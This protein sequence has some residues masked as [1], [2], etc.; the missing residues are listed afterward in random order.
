MRH[1]LDRDDRMRYQFG[2]NPARTLTSE[3][4]RVVQEAIGVRPR[5]SSGRGESWLVV[6]GRPYEDYQAVVDALLNEF[7]A[8]LLIRE[9]PVGSQVITARDYIFF[10]DAPNGR[11][12]G[13]GQISLESAKNWGD[14]RNIII[15]YSYELEDVISAMNEAYEGVISYEPVD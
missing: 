2:S 13:S 1:R 7:R 6:Y 10:V 11:Y 3:I 4:G 5:R 12:L 15:H 14:S 8:W 9:I